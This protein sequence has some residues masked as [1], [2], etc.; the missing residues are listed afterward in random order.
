MGNPLLTF[1]SRRSQREEEERARRARLLAAAASSRKASET[2]FLV[3]RRMRA[4]LIVLIT[5]FSV[6]VLGLTLIPG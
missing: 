3:L 1:W 6:S 5:I 2:V 4:P